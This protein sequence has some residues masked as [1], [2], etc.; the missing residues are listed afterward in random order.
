L[1]AKTR[2]WML[3]YSMKRKRKKSYFTSTHSETLS[4]TYLLKRDWLHR[5]VKRDFLFHV[6]FPR[7]RREW[8]LVNKI[9]L[10]NK[11]NQTNNIYSR[12]H[13]DPQTSKKIRERSGH[14]ALESNILA[15]FSR[16]NGF[17][18]IYVNLQES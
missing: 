11:D 3:F 13:E 6:Q 2:K 7:S 9:N 4:F 14:W 10:Y 18:W 16:F 8:F 1:N 17:C 5:W 12:T 15:I